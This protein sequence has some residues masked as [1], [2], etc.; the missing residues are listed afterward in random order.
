MFG[1]VL[2]LLR[3]HA[4]LDILRLNPPFQGVP[5]R[6]VFAVAQ[7]LLGTYL[8][9]CGRFLP[10]TVAHSCF[11]RYWITSTHAHPRH[12][13]FGLIPRESYPPVNLI[14]RES[15]PPVPVKPQGDETR[16]G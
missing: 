15:Y 14:P 4:R 5:T 6:R 3:Q 1:S 12:P 8:L 16:G 13:P 9:Q 7:V 2:G 10:M 11:G